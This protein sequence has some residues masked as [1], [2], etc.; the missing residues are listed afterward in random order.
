MPATFYPMDLMVEAMPEVLEGPKSAYA[1]W[2]VAS[3]READSSSVDASTCGELTC[4][5]PCPYTFEL[6]RS[7]LP[8]ASVF[9]CLV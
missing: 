9:T 7:N 4:I 1:V 5:G 2:L 8:S 3:M 6:R